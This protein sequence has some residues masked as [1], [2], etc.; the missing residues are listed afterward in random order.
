MTQ[1]L[2]EGAL[3]ATVMLLLVFGVAALLRRASAAARHTVWSSGFAGLL[4]LPFLATT[5]PWR[6]EVL[7]AAA[8]VAAPTVLAPVMDEPIAAP[9]ETTSDAGP[10]AESVANFPD[11]IATQ[12]AASTPGI[13]ASTWLVALWLVGAGLVVGRVVLG[14]FLM[15]WVSRRGE[16]LDD[17][18]W[19]DML[20]AAERRMGITTHVQLL[21]NDRVPMPMTSGLLRPVIVL[22]GDCDEWTDDRRF[23]V[24]LHELAHVRRGDCLTQVLGQ[25]ARAL[26]WFNPLVWL[27]L[28]RLRTEQERACDDIV[29]NCGADANEYASEL[30]SVTARLPRLTWDAAVTLAMSRSNRIEHRL[31]SILNSDC[32]RRQCHGDTS[33]RHV[34]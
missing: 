20:D 4:A 8:N 9:L 21:K 12:A 2:F 19:A 7:P 16:R 22:P 18:A 10:T 31:K 27:A 23:A 34:A 24:L 6:L 25:F 3:K 1:V 29:L 33:W 13:P 11:P 26:H 28:Q 30:L 17:P 32:E 15:L 5:L 14:W